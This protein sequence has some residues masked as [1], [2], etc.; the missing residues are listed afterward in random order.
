MATGHRPVV[1]IVKS[2]I[3]RGGLTGSGRAMDEFFQLY[4]RTVAATPAAAPRF[5]DT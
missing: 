4:R 1:K 5:I 2:A 3:G